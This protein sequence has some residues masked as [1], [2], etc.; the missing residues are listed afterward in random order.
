[1]WSFLYSQSSSH[2]AL[3]FFKLAKLMSVLRPLPLVSLKP[4]VVPQLNYH[5]CLILVLQV[6]VLKSPSPHRNCCC[7]FFNAPA[8]REFF[9]RLCLLIICCKVK[10]STTCKY[11]LPSFII[12]FKM[13]MS[14]GNNVTCC[15]HSCMPWESTKLR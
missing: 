2:T 3:G 13:Y 6:S 8:T 4:G 10:L 1:M 11:L 15:I 14:D 9:T 5:N 7:F 12:C